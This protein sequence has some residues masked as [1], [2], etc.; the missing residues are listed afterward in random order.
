MNEA[1]PRQ[2]ADGASDSA[3]AVAGPRTE[4]VNET[5]VV[6]QSPE[7]GAVE[8]DTLGEVWSTTA[9]SPRRVVT[10]G[11]GAFFTMVTL[12]VLAILAL[13]AATAWLALDRGGEDDPV[14]A[15]VNGEQ[16]HRSDYDKAVAQNGGEQALDG[17]IS[18]KLVETEAKKRS[19][20]V[21]DAETARLLD[22]QKQQFG[23]DSAFQ[24]ALAQA[25]LTEQDLSKQLR[26]NAMLRRMIADNIQVTDQEVD[27]AYQASA[28]Q[29]QGVPEAQAK[30]QVR[31]NLQR[32]KEG[33]AAR[34]FL[35]QL[36][37]DAKIQ[38]KLPG[39]TES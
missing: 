15:T 6:G 30:E 35:E 29:L 39:K 18:E 16:I 21:D 10:I 37:T 11:R 33:G 28:A 27:Q 2:P 31:S 3:R 19:I 24:A 23:S 5:A 22:E 25:G 13:G 34:G 38:S 26:L 4:T 36:R 1:E 12:G 20:T 32:Q 9:P 7:D 17:L 8:Q 14:V